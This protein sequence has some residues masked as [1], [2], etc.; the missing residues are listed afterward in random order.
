MEKTEVV[1]MA[2]PSLKFSQRLEEPLTRP[3]CDTHPAAAQLHPSGAEIDEGQD[4]D[5]GQ[6]LGYAGCFLHLV[7][8]RCTWCGTLA[9]W[10]I[11]ED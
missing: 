11:Q 6:P 1:D 2:Y 9:T 7:K 8:R 4:F 3:F 5:R 10:G